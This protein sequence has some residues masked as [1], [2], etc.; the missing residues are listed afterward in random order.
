VYFQILSVY[1]RDAS[2]E[3]EHD[4]LKQLDAALARQRQGARLKAQN[5]AIAIAS[6]RAQRKVLE[7]QLV[8]SRLE[9]QNDLRIQKCLILARV[10]LD[11]DGHKQQIVV[12]GLPRSG[13]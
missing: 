7:A 1:P 12:A 5:R 3:E 2:L 8:N 4:K 9:A 11:C 10:G 13:K 6:A